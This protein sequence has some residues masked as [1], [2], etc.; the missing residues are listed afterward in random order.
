MMKELDDTIVSTTFKIEKEDRAETATH[1]EK[2]D[3][4]SQYMKTRVLPT[5]YI[6]EG[7]KEP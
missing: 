2:S 3:I 5:K 7:Y 4:L 6:Y 1:Y